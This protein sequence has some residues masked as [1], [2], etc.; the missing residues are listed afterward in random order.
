M[1]GKLGGQA[2]PAWSL[3]YGTAERTGASSRVIARAG[4]SPGHA[5]DRGSGMV[6]SMGVRHGD[7]LVG[8]AGRG[9]SVVAGLAA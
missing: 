3:P 8:W 5:K 1:A 6:A 2:C 7:V 4:G 9:S